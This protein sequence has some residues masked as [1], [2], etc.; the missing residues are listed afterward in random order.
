M[1]SAL[2]GSA[3]GLGRCNP[4]PSIRACRR[5]HALGVLCADLWAQEEF[6]PKQLGCSF[7][8]R[9]RR[10]RP[11][12][13]RR[14]NRDF[15]SGEGPARYFPGRL[16]LLALSASG[17]HPSAPITVERLTLHSA[18]PP[19]HTFV[20]VEAVNLLHHC[21][22]TAWR[23][24]LAEE[25]PSECPPLELGR[26]RNPGAFKFKLT[27]FRESSRD[28]RLS[29]CRAIVESSLA[30]DNDHL[31][32]GIESME[33]LLTEAARLHLEDATL[34]NSTKHGLGVTSK[35]TR[36]TL[37]VDAANLPDDELPASL[38]RDQNGALT[39]FNR[40]GIW[41]EHY[42]T[43]SSE[44]RSRDVWMVTETALKL[45]TTLCKIDYIVSLIDAIWTIGAR[46]FGGA[47]VARL[48][49]PEPLAIEEL[50]ADEFQS[51][52]KSQ[53]ELRYTAWEGQEMRLFIGATGRPGSRAPVEP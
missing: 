11:Y 27:A 30:A 24:F 45:D 51:I 12:A 6:P 48:S 23:L 40:D 42:A 36:I 2:A 5:P 34:Y 32:E 19:G 28:K 4:E 44:S 43:A 50:I 52:V 26:I 21:A 9:G 13:V 16:W 7:A 20:A 37:S 10:P 31:T 15:F 29:R 33:L 17:Q 53:R 14:V 41:L 18:V 3:H 47:E 8:A 39:L 22:E 25:P 46:R 38:T 35:H 1:R 49:L